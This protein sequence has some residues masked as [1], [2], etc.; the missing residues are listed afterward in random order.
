MTTDKKSIIHLVRICEEKG[1]RDIVFSPGSRNAA[2]IIAFTRSKQI[3]CHIVPDERVAGFLAL[4]MSIHS[5]VP[6]ILCCT[7][8]SAALNYS[9][10]VAEAYY[11]S[12]PLLIITADRPVEWIDQ[13]IGQSMRQKDLFHNYIK[14]NFQYAQEAETE[15][16]LWYNDRQIN[17]AINLSLQ[18]QKG[19]VHINIPFEEPLYNQ[20]EDDSSSKVKTIKQASVVQDIDPHDLK[21]LLEIWNESKRKII[22]IGQSKKNNTLEQLLK[23]L[24]NRKDVILLSETCSNIDI[25]SHIECIDRIITTFEGSENLIQPD[26]LISIGGPVISKKVKRLFRENKPRHHWYINSGH[27][28]DTFQALDFHIGIDPS[29]ILNH[30]VLSASPNDEEYTGGW[31][32]RNNHIAQLHETF[33]EHCPYSDLKV[34]AAIH[35]SL[36]EN[37]VLHTSNSTPVRYMQ[38][39]SR[40]KGIVY[41]ANRGVSGIDGC[42]ST[43]MGYAIKSD[44][45]NLLVTG[46]IAFFYDSNAFW[47]DQLTD[48]LKII[49]INNGGGGIFRIIEGPSSTDVL[50]PYFEARH[51]TNARHIASTFG[52]E[53]SSIDTEEDLHEGIKKFINS[54]HGTTGIL[55][56]FSPPETNDRVL[57]E[58]FDFL[59][60]E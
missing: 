18:A 12:V 50:E 55:E 7:S 47:H 41:Q 59:K 25:N 23:T 60:Q 57:K 10:A 4:G 48:N 5:E 35:K 14:G 22:L 38:L 45:Q 37:I 8:G 32:K 24:V 39:F 17:E 49:I 33:I 21:S 20:L 16:D 52:L 40:N 27:A 31:E 53:Y 58:Y 43:A 46:D 28:Q 44:K 29:R 15:N 26:L 3:N 13:G 56:I 30:L 9:P 36:P 34:F 51:K 1:I 42:T 11:Q 54:H 19:P 2:L 6:T